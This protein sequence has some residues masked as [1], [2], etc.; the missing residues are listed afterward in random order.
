MK[1]IIF[2]LTKNS[3]SVSTKHHQFP[4]LQGAARLCHAAPEAPLQATPQ[5]AQGVQ[6]VVAG[7][8]L[9]SS[10]GWFQ[11]TVMDI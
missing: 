10:G 9:C 4:Q 11:P 1:S 3:F 8:V 2:Q 5:Q 7:E 6:A